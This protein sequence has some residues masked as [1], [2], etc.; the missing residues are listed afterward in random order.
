MSQNLRL[1]YS[2]SSAEMDQARSLSLRKQLGGGS[3]WRTNIILLAA[4]VVMLFGA[5]FRFR[6]ISEGYRALMLGAIVGCS[7]LFVVWKRKFRKTVPTTTQL[8]ISETDFMILAAD[9]KVVLPWSAFS[10]CLES[11][12]LFVLL[13]RPKRMLIVVPKRAF[14]SESWQTW[15]RE[16][17][18]HKPNLIMS[19]P[20][21]VPVPAPSKAA[22]RVTLTVHPRFLDYLDCTVASW[23]TRGICLVLGSFLIGI[24]LYSA[25]NPPPDAVNS[26]TKVFVFFV[27]PFFLV[28]VTMI[29]M[30]LSIHSWR[31]S[32][33]YAGAQEIALSEQSMTFSGPDGSGVLPWTRFE[34]YK[35]TPWNFI[36]WRGSH[37]MMLP[38]RAF[39]SWDELN[40]CRDILDHH[41]QHSRWFVG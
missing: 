29:V 8:E 2:C 38:K 6:E 35:E 34:N 40:R 1:E 5:W 24:S 16:Q 18:T 39:S 7:V 27:I 31:I 13:D 14:P 23:R 21:E 10:E 41:L 28:V 30:M 20:S 26:A 17:A 19:A 36:V 9:S 4:L 12:D 15:F 22:D 37:W 33:K 25:A 11:T 3:K 32:A